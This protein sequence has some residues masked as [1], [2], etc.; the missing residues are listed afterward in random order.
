MS[1]NYL[2]K[3]TTMIKDLPI[4]LHFGDRPM[5]RSPLHDSQKDWVGLV[6]GGTDQ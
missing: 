3:T 5:V 4:D 1:V 6:R 2:T